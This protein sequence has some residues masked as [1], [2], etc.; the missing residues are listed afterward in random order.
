MTD[1]AQAT[2]APARLHLQRRHHPKTQ[3]LWQAMRVMRRFTLGQLVCTVDGG[4]S[5]QHA[6]AFV[7]RLATCAYVRTVRARRLGQ[8]GEQDVLAL[9]RDT[10]PLAPTPCHRVVGLLDH[11][12]G[13]LIVQGGQVAPQQPV[14][15]R[16]VRMA[17]GKAPTALQRQALARLRDGLPTLQ[18]MSNPGPLG[19]VLAGLRGRGLLDEAGAITAA[20]HALLASAAA[21]SQGG[22]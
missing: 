17:P 4:M 21:G 10:G 16:N 18:D 5:V 11:N 9:V 19:K 22:A 3:Q 14:P 12:L 8:P 20:G 6:R 2:A 7:Q 15:Q 13:L 1:G